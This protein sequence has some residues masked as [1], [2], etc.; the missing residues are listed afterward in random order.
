VVSQD[1]K[2]SGLRAILNYGHTI[3]HAVE[4]LTG[5]TVVIHG[6][7]VAIGM[8]AASQIA[9]KLGLWDEDSDLRQFDIIEKAKLPTQLPPGL[10]IDEILESLQTDKKV[11]A[12]KVRFVLPTR[13]GAA[14][15]TDIVTSDI[16]R[17]VLETSPVRCLA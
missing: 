14:T 3:G 4:S 6:E 11:K 17:Q 2:E 1:E 8:V 12:G 13:I 15:V 7:A 5:Y 10:N 9:L 16:I